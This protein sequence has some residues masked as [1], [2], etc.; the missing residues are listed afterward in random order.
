MQRILPEAAGKLLR[1]QRARGR[2]NFMGY[3]SNGML[4]SYIPVVLAAVPSTLTLTRA[5]V[6]TAASQG[7]FAS[8]TIACSTRGDAVAAV[9]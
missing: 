4:P 3:R 6:P 1:G 5:V 9:A 7:T 2:W 8:S